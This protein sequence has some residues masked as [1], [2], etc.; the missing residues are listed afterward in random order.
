MTYRITQADIEQVERWVASIQDIA[1]RLKEG[2]AEHDHV[3]WLRERG[4]DIVALLKGL[5]PDR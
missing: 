1:L 3:K 2:G 4:D 5:E